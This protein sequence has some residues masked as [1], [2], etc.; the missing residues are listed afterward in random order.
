M[1]GRCNIYER[2]TKEMMKRGLA[3]V[4]MKSKG[5]QLQGGGK[6]SV[7]RPK[8]NE[9]KD[10]HLRK[11]NMMTELNIKTDRQADQA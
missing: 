9:R 7:R 5:S 6:E 2:A 4:G 10:T 11:Q 8:L 3:L 1:H